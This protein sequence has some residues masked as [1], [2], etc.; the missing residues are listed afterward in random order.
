MA[1]NLVTHHLWQVSSLERQITRSRLLFALDP[2]PGYRAFV[3][4]SSNP[5]SCAKGQYLPRKV[6]DG[7][8]RFEDSAQTRQE[9][10]MGREGREGEVLV[11]EVRRCV[12]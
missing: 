1:S 2:N 12:V 11:D 10:Q 4:R 7:A 8:A 3:P 6:M 5:P 9:K